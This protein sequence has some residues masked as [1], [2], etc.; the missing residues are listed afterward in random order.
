[1]IAPYPQSDPTLRDAAAEK[2]IARLVE[3]VTAIRSLRAEYN[4]P[5]GKKIGAY[6]MTDDGFAREAV[7]AFGDEIRKLSDLSQFAVERRAEAPREAAIGHLDWCEVVVPLSGA[8]DLD[9]ERARLRKEIDKTGKEHDKL[10][11]KLQNQG[12]L[13]KAPPDVVEKDKARLVELGTIKQKLA[14]TLQRLGG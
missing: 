2:E 5:A 3:V 7:L 1:M 9:V 6:V 13:A 14:D 8:I 12:F 10:E 11:A 4:V